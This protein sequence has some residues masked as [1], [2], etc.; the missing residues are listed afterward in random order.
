MKEKQKDNT[1][2]LEKTKGYIQ[3]TRQGL[4]HLRGYL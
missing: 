1:L 2:L 3:N 4:E